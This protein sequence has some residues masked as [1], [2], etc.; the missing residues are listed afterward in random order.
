MNMKRLTSK[1]GFTLIELLVVIAIIAILIALLLPA[2]QQAR[3]AA[4]RSTCKNNMKQLGLALHNY[5]ETHGVLPPGAINPAGARTAGFGS[6]EATNGLNHTGFTLLLPFIDQ[7]PLYNKWNFDIASGGATNGFF[8]SVAGGWPNSNTPLGQTI[9]PALLCPSDE[10]QTLEVRTDSSWMATSAARSNYL[11]CAGGHGNGWP[12]GNLYSAY[13]ESS[14]NLPNGQT[15]IQYQGMFGFNGAAKFKAVTDGLS[16]SIAMTEGCIYGKRD[17]AYSPLWAQHRYAG[18]FAV[19]HP[20]I[21][22]SHINN[23]RYHINGPYDVLGATGAGS[24]DDPRIY[25]EVASSVHEGGCHVLMGD[26]AVRF[27]SENMDHSQ[28]ALLTRIH[29][30]QPTGEY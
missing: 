28:Y 30:G 12:G 15:G 9:L 23:K 5:N 13:R 11:F 8:T 17:D 4:R 6:E 14:S 29:D 2:V 16:N 24:A 1:R 18:T 25:I 10:G 26:G 19:N 21:D 7:G 27:L 3:E 22:A 20:N